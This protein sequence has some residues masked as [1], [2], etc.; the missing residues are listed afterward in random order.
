MVSLTSTWKAVPANSCSNALQRSVR[1]ISAK[2][3]NSFTFDADSMIDFESCTQLSKPSKGDDKKCNLT[4]TPLKHESFS[5]IILISESKRAE[6]LEGNSGEYKFTKP[7]ELLDDSDPDM[8]MFK[9]DIILDR[10]CDTSIKL[11]LTGI[12]E[13]CWLL[14]VFVFMSEKESIPPNI[15][16]LLNQ[17]KQTRF[18]LE[19]MNSLLKETKLSGK[20]QSF[21]NLF[22]TFQKTGPYSTPNGL[23]NLDKMNMGDTVNSSLMSDISSTL[24]ANSSE[25]KLTSALYDD[26]INK[27]L[28]SDKFSV[29]NKQYFA[30]N[31]M[32]DLR[33][34]DC[35]CNHKCCEKQT[36]IFKET[37]EQIESN[38]LEKISELEK[39]QDEK[40]NQILDILSKSTS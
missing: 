3:T 37:L 30:T 4:I 14:G 27:Q 19:Q 26:V 22:E 38:V 40:F 28:N 17:G 12:E 35:K 36:I 6:V 23:L 29:L 18:D 5:R 1:T 21:K 20:A 7:A 10:P 25:A 16:G 39:K 33:S 15:N 8:I 24:S 31:S 11:Y 32:N 9:N 13:S 34:G 2:E